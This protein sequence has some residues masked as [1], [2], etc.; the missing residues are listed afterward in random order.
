MPTQVN[1]L[2]R[3]IKAVRIPVKRLGIHR[4]R[5]NGVRADE[6]TYRGIIISGTVIIK[7]GIIQPL[8]GKKFIRWEIIR[9]IS[10]DSERLITLLILSLSKGEF[11][12]Q[13]RLSIKCYLTFLTW[14]H[15]LMI[16]M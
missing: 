9:T 8:P 1:I 2:Q 6:T 16:T 15:R 12:Q 7:P 14:L 10:E 3:V 13:L 11:L 4:V 5:N